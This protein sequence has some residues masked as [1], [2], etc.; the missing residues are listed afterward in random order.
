MNISR[1]AK[2]ADRIEIRLTGL[3]KGRSEDL[4]VAIRNA[5][6]GRSLDELSIL[7]PPAGS[8]MTIAAARWAARQQESHPEFVAYQDGAIIINVS[9]KDFVGVD[10]VEWEMLNE[11]LKGTIAEVVSER[12]ARA[13]GVNSPQSPREKAVRENLAA[14]YVGS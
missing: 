1:A 2:V 14:Y 6:G 7:T 4:Y 12:P 11:I 3:D 9:A 10:A 8:A 5:S 13:G